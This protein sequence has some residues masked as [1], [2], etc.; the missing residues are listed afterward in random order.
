MQILLEF[1][2]SF[3]SKIRKVI[4][5]TCLA[6]SS[7]LVMLVKGTIV[8]TICTLHCSVLYFVS[9]GHA[10]SGVL[11]TSR[12][13]N[14]RLILENVVIINVNAK[15]IQ[16]DFSTSFGF[17]LIQILQIRDAVWLNGVRRHFFG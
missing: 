13:L 17:S 14:G 9:F 6:P 2:P 11:G 3:Q 1:Q 16:E 15:C 12:V 4:V 10:S 7:I 8:Y 5:F